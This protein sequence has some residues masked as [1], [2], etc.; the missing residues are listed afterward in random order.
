M[1]FISKFAKYEFHA[2]HE[3]VEPLANG[4]TR[5]LSPG[6]KCHFQVSDKTDWEAEL[7]RK[8]FKFSGVPMSMDGVL[9]DPVPSRVSSYD[10]D[11]DPRLK[12]DR[13]AKR[14]GYASAEA[15]KARVEERLLEACSPE[16]HISAVKPKA[17]E[18]W[19]GY[20]KLVAQGRRTN[21]LIAEK[22]AERVQEDGYEP[23]DIAS[24]IAYE[25]G[26]LNRP[27]VIEALEALTADDTL[28]AA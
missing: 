27:E 23:A 16:A 21:A 2:L 20:D 10:T 26:N 13:L 7:A 9:I 4:Q 28:I 11:L 25:R 8:T 12:D 24:V 6:F 5:T 1:R 14:H 3:I 19:R 18:P 17:E 15:L 22:I